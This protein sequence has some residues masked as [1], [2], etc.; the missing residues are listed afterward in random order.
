MVV[1]VCPNVRAIV[2]SRSLV[3][4]SQNCAPTFLPLSTVVSTATAI[5][6]MDRKDNGVK[7]RAKFAERR[8]ALGIVRT[9]RIVPLS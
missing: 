6:E 2:I 3:G 1:D 5:D 7:K 8:T 9:T 4:Q